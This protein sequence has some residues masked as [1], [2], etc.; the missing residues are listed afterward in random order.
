M[1]KRE[2]IL[3]SLLVSSLLL[4]L[5]ASQIGI[6]LAMDKI[7]QSVYDGSL[8]SFNHENGVNVSHLFVV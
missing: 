4:I 8:I 2:S 5:G 1:K 3:F 6:D 7:I